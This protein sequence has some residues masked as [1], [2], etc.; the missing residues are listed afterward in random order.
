MKINSFEPDSNQR[1]KDDNLAATVLRSPN[2]AIEG[3]DAWELIISWQLCFQ[4][5]TYL[6]KWNLKGRAFFS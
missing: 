1:P 6:T 2:W 3:I 4:K 5:E